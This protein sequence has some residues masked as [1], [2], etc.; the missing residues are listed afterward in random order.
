MIYSGFSMPIGLFVE[1]FS[2]D[3]SLKVKGGAQ[4]RFEVFWSRFPRM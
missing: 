3:D 2:Q 4:R 1:R